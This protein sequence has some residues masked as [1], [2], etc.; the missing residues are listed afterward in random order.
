MCLELTFE[1]HGPGIPDLARAMESGFST[2]KGMGLGL[3]G[4]KRLMDEFE[5]E[6]T[7][8]KGTR[9]TVENGCAHDMDANHVHKIPI[10]HQSDVGAGRRA[11]A[12]LAQSLGFAEA[13]G[14][15][16]GLAAMELATNLIK[17]ASSGHLTMVSLEKDGRVGL[18][19]RSDDDGPGI[20]DV[21]KAMIDGYSAVGSHGTGLGAVNR[22]MDEFAITSRLGKGT[23]IVCRKWI[24]D[25]RSS[26]AEHLLTVGVASRPRRAGQDNG[27][28]FVV[29]R[30]NE[31]L[32]VG[33]VDGLGHGAPARYASMAALSYVEAHFDQPLEQIFRGAGDTCRATRGVVMA[34]AQFDLR[35][36]RMRFATVGNIEARVIPLSRKFIF[37]NRRG[38]VG[39]GTPRAGISE[40]P[41]VNEDILILSS[42]GIRTHWN[43]AEFPR[44]FERPAAEIAQQ[45]LRALA[46]DDDDATVLVVRG[47][48]ST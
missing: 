8:G 27:D 32:L 38:I 5:I 11:A 42:D 9:V 39:Q 44:L 33:I 1:D 21:G 34:L 36:S 20:Q 10:A 25:F 47:R 37:P 24:R 3:P 7:I 6:S 18:E 35:Y 28:A 43:P 15:E 48:A 29:K 23:S 17:H 4:S 13:A 45:L 26:D 14:E 2:G 30:A 46:R 40:N 41:W 22:L 12:E 16:I 19:L 31:S